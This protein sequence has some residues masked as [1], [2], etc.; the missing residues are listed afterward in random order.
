MQVKFRSVT[1]A[2]GVMPQRKSRKVGVSNDF[3]RRH[4][5]LCSKKCKLSFVSSLICCVRL[6]GNATFTTCF[7]PRGE[8]VLS[9]ILLG[10]RHV[11]KCEDAF[12]FKTAKHGVAHGNKIGGI[13]TAVLGHVVRGSPRRTTRCRT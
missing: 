1:S 12:R 9:S 7:A 2:V 8:R 10:K 11:F 4:P 6:I 13:S 3:R 5:R